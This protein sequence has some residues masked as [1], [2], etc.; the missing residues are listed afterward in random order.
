MLDVLDRTMEERKEIINLFK[1]LYRLD[2]CSA[3]TE[4]Y[5]CSCQGCPF[6]DESDNRCMLLKIKDNLR[7]TIEEDTIED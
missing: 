5:D 3:F 6:L 2:S 4:G 1:E 7:G